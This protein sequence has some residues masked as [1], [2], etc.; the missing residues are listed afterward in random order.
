MA[1]L[2][3]RS[4]TL[5]DLRVLVPMAARFYATTGYRAISETPS[6]K[7]LANIGAELI[8]NGVFLVAERAGGIVGMV[9][10][11]FAPFL[12]DPKHRTAHEVMWWVEPE[13]QGAGAGRS[14][15]LGAIEACRKGG[16]RAIQMLH[17]ASSPAH[18]ADAYLAAGFVHSE[19]SYMKVLT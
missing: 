15:L 13:A 17:L 11:V 6:D 4:A 10:L 16:I 14:L 3:I 5:D 12:F 18:A 1:E 9:G 7:A 19:S 2:R 8:R